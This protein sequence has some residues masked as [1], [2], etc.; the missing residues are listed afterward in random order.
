MFSTS[1]ST[2]YWKYAWS[3]STVS[4]PAPPAVQVAAASR[5]V[6]WASLTCAQAD[7]AADEQIAWL[8]EELHKP[9]PHCGERRTAD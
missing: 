8:L 5:H 7:R 3:D 4:N 6:P 1:S 9:C 2:E